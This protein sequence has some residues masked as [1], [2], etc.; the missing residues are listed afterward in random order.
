M[1]AGEVRHQ[2]RAI[3]TGSILTISILALTL[4]LGSAAAAFGAPPTDRN[5]PRGL[6]NARLIGRE[7]SGRQIAVILTLD[8]RDKAGVDALIAAQHDPSSPQY[9]Q[10]VSPEEFQ[11][12]FGPLPEDIEAAR[13]F[14]QAQGFTNVTQPTS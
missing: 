3:L 9:H 2:S 8:L 14:L 7:D 4:A 5:T 12:R 11:A 1:T 13:Q 10:W 6:Q